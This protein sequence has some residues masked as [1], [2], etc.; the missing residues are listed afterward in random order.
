MQHKFN[1][2]YKM[3][4]HNK[5]FKVTMAEFKYKRHKTHHKELLLPFIMPRLMKIN[6]LMKIIVHI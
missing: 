5:W 1:K 4:S 6:H 3:L 2:T